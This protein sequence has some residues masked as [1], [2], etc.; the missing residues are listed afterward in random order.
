MCSGMQQRLHDLVSALHTHDPAKFMDDHPW[1][2][3]CHG[4]N[5]ISSIRCHAAALWSN[6]S[7]VRSTV[8]HHTR[9]R[10]TD[11]QTCS[12]TVLHE[13]ERFGRVMTIRGV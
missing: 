9:L 2:G 7:L 1:P 11:C 10:R 12:V 8:R 5:D 4:F 3:S 13:V 6:H